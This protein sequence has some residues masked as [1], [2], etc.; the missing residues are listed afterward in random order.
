MNFQNLTNTI[1]FPIQ[2]IKKLFLKEKK[3]QYNI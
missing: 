2:E 1:R 3:V